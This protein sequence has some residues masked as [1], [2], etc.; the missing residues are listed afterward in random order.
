M[1]G[2][3]WNRGDLGIG[4]KKLLLA[5]LSLILNILRFFD[6]LNFSTSVTFHKIGIEKNFCVIDERK[7]LSKF[8]TNFV[9]RLA[10]C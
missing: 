8:K 2:L 10:S 5:Q 1:I 3:N 9:F 7:K 4:T 6:W